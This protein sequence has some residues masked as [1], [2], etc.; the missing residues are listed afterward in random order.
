[1]IKLGI[2]HP[3]PDTGNPQLFAYLRG[4][5]DQR[6]LIVNNFSETDQVMTAGRL[7][8]AGVSQDAWEHIG[9][10]SLTEGEDLVLEGYRYVWIDVAGR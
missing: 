5:G 4:S 9:R 1:M 7:A 2:A 10:R 6:L 3:S 8:A